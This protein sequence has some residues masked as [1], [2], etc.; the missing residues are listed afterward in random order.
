MKNV[1]AAR[2]KENDNNYPWKLVITINSE[3]IA[4]LSQIMK[5]IVVD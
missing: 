5:M 2:I 1:I 4:I 3:S